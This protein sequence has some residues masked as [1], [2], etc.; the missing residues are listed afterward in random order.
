MTPKADLEGG[1]CR[2]KRLTRIRYS[3]IRKRLPKS[4]GFDYIDEQTMSPF[5]ILTTGIVVGWGFIAHCSFCSFDTALAEFPEIDAGSEVG[6]DV[7]EGVG[8]VEHRKLLMYEY[9]SRKVVQTVIR[10]AGLQLL[11]HISDY[12]HVHV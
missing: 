6:S 11:C 3:K 4:W 9:M 1:M 7:S 2:H 8:D 12:M 5:I 10:R